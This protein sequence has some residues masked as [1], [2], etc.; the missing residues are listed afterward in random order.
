MKIINSKKN[1]F[2]AILK[3]L[4]IKSSITSAKIQIIYEM[5]NY[6]DQKEQEYRQQDF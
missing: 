2:K 1:N 3:H 5:K 4:V 6:N